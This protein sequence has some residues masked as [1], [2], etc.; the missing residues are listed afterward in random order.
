MISVEPDGGEMIVQGGKKPFTLQ[1]LEHS[2]CA[3]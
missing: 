1:F 2:K 3:H